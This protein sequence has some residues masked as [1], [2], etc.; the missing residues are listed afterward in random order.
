MM[1]NM[2]A[3][4]ERPSNKVLNFL[5]ATGGL[6]VLFT[7]LAIVDPRVR[8][9]IA[10][11]VSGQGASGEVG[12]AVAQVQRVVEVAFVAMRDQSLAYA[13]LTIFG[14]AAIVLFLFMKRT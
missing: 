8:D 1:I 2:N 14:L 5:L 12:S 4:M 10:Q 11:I 9:Q 6:S 13:P 3:A 7:G